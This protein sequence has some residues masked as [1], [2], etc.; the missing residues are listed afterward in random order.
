MQLDSWG[1]PISIKSSQ[2][3][4]EEELGIGTSEAFLEG[5]DKHRVK[6]VGPKKHKQSAFQALG[7]SQAVCDGIRKTGYRC[8]TPIQRAAIPAILG[9]QDVFAMARTGSGKTACFLLPM[10]EALKAHSARSGARALILVPTRELAVQTLKFAVNLGKFTGLH[11]VLVVGGESMD[12][13]FN[14][15]HQQPD[16]IIATPGRLMHVCVEMELRLDNVQYVVFDEADR[17]FEMGFREQLEEILARLAVNRQTLLFSATLPKMLAEFA[18]AGLNNP[19][20]IRLD[21]DDKLSEALQVAYFSVQNNSKLHLLLFILQHVIKFNEQVIIFAATQFQVQFLEQALEKCNFPS[22]YLFSDMDPTSRKINAAKFQ[23]KTVNILI[24][25]DIAGRGID[26]P[27]L[28]YVINYDF[29][30]NA[31]TFIHRVGRAARAGKSGVALSFVAVEEEPFLWDLSRFLGRSVLFSPKIETG[32]KNPVPL[33]MNPQ[34]LVQ[35]TSCAPEKNDEKTKPS[36][37][38][39]FH[40]GKVPQEI[41]S[42]ECDM[43][44]KLEEDT[45][46][47]YLKRKSDNAYQMYRR[48]CPKPTREALKEMKL[49][50]QIISMGDHPLLVKSFQKNFYFTTCNLDEN[51][52]QQRKKLMEELKNVK[53][54]KTIFEIGVTGMRDRAKVMKKKRER[55]D[56]YIEKYQAKLDE[57]RAK[58]D[59]MQEFK[60]KPVDL[61]MVA[62]DDIQYEFPQ[63]LNT[64]DAMQIVV[65]KFDAERREKEERDELRGKKISKRQRRKEKA[66]AGNSIGK[67]QEAAGTG[68]FFIPY[69]PSDAHEDKGYRVN[70]STSFASESLNA[71]MDTMEDNYLGM[72]RLKTVKRWDVKKNKFV[73]PKATEKKIRTEC[74]TTIRSSYKTDRYSMWLK[75]NRLDEDQLQAA[76]GADFDL[77]KKPDGKRELFKVISTKSES[78]IHP[79]LQAQHKKGLETGMPIKEEVRN[80]QQIAKERKLQKRYQSDRD[81]GKAMK[82]IRGKLLGNQARKRKVPKKKHV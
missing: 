28:D 14:A 5:A 19:A 37:E 73:G 23:T 33:D 3:P 12:Q 81:R 41:I 72:A 36:V 21:K 49:S 77:D 34:N 10:F 70:E 17:L 63:T 48:N 64:Q 15:L 35:N 59:A 65:E 25:T 9:G 79:L 18:K 57:K 52:L 62:D 13:Q 54:K 11:C 68:N 1:A 75:R 29:P 60:N 4:E 22:A 20:M 43:V 45:E 38:W 31:K 2:D 30:P 26:I 7:F 56:E 82:K 80:E 39:N 6:N 32:A 44:A 51:L 47:M 58:Y 69:A 53:P 66:A 16:I 42:E 8:P 76:G 46:L 40:F 74:G 24:A 78:K 50:R 71:E 55:D 67:K 27:S 61:P